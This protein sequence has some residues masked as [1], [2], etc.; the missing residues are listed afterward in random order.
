MNIHN[1][2]SKK[3]QYFYT[4]LFLNNYYPKKEVK[5]EAVIP[6]TKLFE[7]CADTNT[8]TIKW[9]TPDKLWVRHNM[10]YPLTLE[11]WNAYNEHIFYCPILKEDIDSLTVGNVV[12]ESGTSLVLSFTDN[13]PPRGNEIFKL[14]I[15]SLPLFDLKHQDFKLPQLPLDQRIENNQTGLAIIFRRNTLDSLFDL[16]AEFDET[17]WHSMEQNFDLQ[18]LTQE[19]CYKDCYFAR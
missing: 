17:Y 4:V 19:S 2:H 13:P 10:R 12:I 15:R 6:E 11:M 7:I 14:A 16:I 9:L 8:S 18:Y 3:T 5:P 1:I